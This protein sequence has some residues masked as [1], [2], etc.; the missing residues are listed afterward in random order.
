MLTTPDVVPVRFATAIVLA[1]AA[2]ALSPG[3]GEASCGEYVTIHDSAPAAHEQ[4]VRQD[5]PASPRQPCD[6]PFCSNRPAAPRSP[7]TT[8]PTDTNPSKDCTSCAANGSESSGEA[9]FVLEPAGHHYSAQLLTSIF[10]PPR[11]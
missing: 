7:L 11:A 10:H 8:P 9:R 1:V 6:G 5:H 2:A 4:S 3:R